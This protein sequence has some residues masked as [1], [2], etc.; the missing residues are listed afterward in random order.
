VVNDFERPARLYRN[1]GTENHRIMVR[2]AGATN[3]WGIGA[4][5]RVESGRAPGAVLDG[6]EPRPILLTR[7]PGTLSPAPSGGEGRGEGARFMGSDLFLFE[8]PSEHEPGRVRGAE[9]PPL[10]A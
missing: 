10:A 1:R 9:G 8:L 6:I 7:P 3:R 4:T 5:I 2:L